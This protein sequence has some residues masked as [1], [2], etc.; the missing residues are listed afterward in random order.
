MGFG[1][2]WKQRTGVGLLYKLIPVNMLFDGGIIASANDS[3]GVS[4]QNGA[5]ELYTDFSAVKPL[6]A[7]TLPQ[8][9][10]PTLWPRTTRKSA[11]LSSKV[12]LLAGNSTIARGI[13]KVTN[14]SQQT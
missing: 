2:L 4:A 8:A 6:R 14:Q 13:V 10:A 1:G 3:R 5:S 12:R 11:C 9:S 7:A